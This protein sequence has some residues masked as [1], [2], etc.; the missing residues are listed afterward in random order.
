M[1]KCAVVKDMEINKN[2]PKWIKHRIRNRHEVHKK[3]FFGLY[4]QLYYDFNQIRSMIGSQHY[5]NKK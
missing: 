4:E 3:Q 5:C 1:K 2:D